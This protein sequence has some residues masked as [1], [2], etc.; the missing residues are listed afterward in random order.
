MACLPI[1]SILKS[2]DLN[3]GGIRSLYL[4]RASEVTGYTES[5]GTVTAISL[6]GGSA[7]FSTYQFNKAQANYTETGTVSLENGTFF[8]AQL[9]TIKLV[10]RQVSTRNSLML[11]ANGLQDLVAIIEDQNGLFWYFGAENAVN[12]ASL[13]GGSGAAKGDSNSYDITISG[14]EPELAFEVSSGIV[15]ALIA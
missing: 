10:R 7:G 1:N 14:E 15:S 2:C 3:T 5:N 11:L 13:G 12:L 6:S 8:V 9:I 4:I